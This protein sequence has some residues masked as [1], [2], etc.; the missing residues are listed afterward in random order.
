MIE[1]KNLTKYYGPVMA[2]EDVSFSVKKGEILGLLGPNAA[3]KTTTM[4]IL[5][6]FLS[7]TRGEARVAGFDVSKDPL[8]VRRR[9]GYL[10][11]NA[12]LYLDM[13]VSGYLK[14]MAQIK[15]IEPAKRKKSITEVMENCGIANVSSRIIGHLSKGYRQ[16]VCLAQALLNQPQVLILDEPTLG[17]DPKQIIETRELIKKLAGKRTVILSTH[18]LPEV[19]MTCQRVV[20]I[21][22]GRVVAED[23]P[24]NLARALEKSNQILLKIEG[25]SSEVASELAKI[26]GVLRVN[27][28]DRLSQN[29][30]LY[31]VESE[32]DI[33]IRRELSSKIVHKDWGLLE[34]RL[35]SMNLEDV[36][37]KLATEEKTQR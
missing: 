8:E 11:E 5:T 4:R 12:P 25:P 19:S 17:L 26:P 14:F 22:E 21:N 30:H 15:G 7:P 31:L 13:R 27:L 18:I 23:T 33:D 3:G 32:K 2:V 6:C 35:V 1:V 16:R 20:I 9:I 37:V 24:Q 29:M 34:I 36:F 10:P 28:K